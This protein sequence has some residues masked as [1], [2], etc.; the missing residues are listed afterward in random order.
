MTK[1]PSDIL[2]GLAI[3]LVGARMSSTPL[4]V[5]DIQREYPDIATKLRGAGYDEVDSEVV[6]MLIRSGDVP[7]YSQT[8][9]PEEPT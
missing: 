9:F 6:R 1:Y 5:R 8:L 4:Y 7:R 3:R 2:I